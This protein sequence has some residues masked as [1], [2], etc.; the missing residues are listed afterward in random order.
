VIELEYPLYG[1]LGAVV[2]TLIRW[3]FWREKGYDY[4]LRHFAWG[5]VSGLI[6]QLFGLPNHLTAFGLGY[7]GIDVAEG[8]LNRLVR[9]NENGLRL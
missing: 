8:F 1:V 2:Y 3:G 5:F 6:V 7:L 9:K 4:L